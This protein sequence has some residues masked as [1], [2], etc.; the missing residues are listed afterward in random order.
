MMKKALPWIAMVCVVIALVIGLSVTSD[1][2]AVAERAL[3]EAFAAALYGSSENAQ[4]LA[5]LLEKAA[6]SSDPRQ[7][8]TLLAQASQTADTLAQSIVFLPLS[9]EAMASTVAFL[10]QVSDD[11]LAIAGSTAAGSLPDAQAVST[12]TQHRALC[13]QLASHLALAQQEAASAGIMS[14]SMN[15]FYEQPSAGERPLEAVQDG[16]GAIDYP[17]QAAAAASPRGLTGPSVTAQ[18][19]LEIARTFVGEDRFVSAAPAPNT[20]GAIPAFGVTVMTDGLQLN[21][22]VTV[23]GGKIL[24]MMPET[25]SFAQLMSVE[26]C[27][28]ASDRFLR[29]RG[30]GDMK[31]IATQVYDGLCVATYAAV[32]DGVVLYPDMIRVQTRMDE[33]DVVGFEAHQY[34]MNHASRELPSPTVSE[35]E[36]RQGLSQAVSVAGEGELCLISWRQ[37][38]RL[39][40]SF[41]VSRDGTSYMIFIDAFTG[42]ELEVVRIIRQPDGTLAA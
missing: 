18:Q 8:V 7:I 14:P 13:M 41:H 40:W 21:L 35:G 38:E 10:H 42:R 28:A 24:W 15:A 11:A 39:C 26:A 25:A 12:L 16:S 37:S 34:W 32:Q 27:T 30:F 31:L 23:T 9:H 6:V 22:E 29:E 2:A 36:A 33:G 3:T 1:R 19:A 20:S 5:L 4:S 17:V